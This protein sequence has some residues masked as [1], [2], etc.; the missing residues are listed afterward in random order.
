M[1]ER[2]QA[3]RAATHAFDDTS[4]IADVDWH[5]YVSSLEARLTSMRLRLA[6]APLATCAD[7]KRL[8]CRKGLEQYVQALACETQGSEIDG[9]A[10]LSAE[11]NLRR[12]MNCQHLARQMHT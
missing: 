3:K 11:T 2:S 4:I 8:Q 5:V 10:M 6:L 9:S 7:D 1:R 12:C